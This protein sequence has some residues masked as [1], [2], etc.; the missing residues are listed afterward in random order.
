MTA[1]PASW[2]S[3]C[4]GYVILAAKL[5]IFS[6]MCKFSITFAESSL[7]FPKISSFTKKSLFDLYISKKMCT[8]APD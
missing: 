6:D 2:V 4:G 8:F 1:I 7:K 3:V 5:L